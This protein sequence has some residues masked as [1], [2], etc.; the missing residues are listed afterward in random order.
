MR[1]MAQTDGIDSWWEEELG[2]LGQRQKCD[3][4][5]SVEDDDVDVEVPVV[6]DS[7]PE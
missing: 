4:M 6:V 2:C 7:T 1:L 3:L 5:E